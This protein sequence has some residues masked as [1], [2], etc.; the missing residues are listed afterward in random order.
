MFLVGNLSEVRLFVLGT[1]SWLILVILAT[2]L[3]RAED[4]ATLP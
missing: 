1:I 3:A 4:P 2:A